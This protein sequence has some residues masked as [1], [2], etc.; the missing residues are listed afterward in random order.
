MGS[1]MTPKLNPMKC[2]KPCLMLVWTQKKDVCFTDLSEQN[3]KAHLQT[4]RQNEVLR[5]I[6]FDNKIKI[7]IFGIHGRAGNWE[8]RTRR[9]QDK[10]FSLHLAIDLVDPKV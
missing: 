6:F 9:M 5:H 3:V 1:P 4:L 7:S 2:K 8:T 10:N